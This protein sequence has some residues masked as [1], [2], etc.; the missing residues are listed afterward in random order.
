MA[1]KGLLMLDT[2]AV[3]ALSRG[4]GPALS[5]RLETQAFCIS[6]IAEAELRFGLARRPVHADVRRIVEALLATVEIRP[7]TT[8]C[9]ASYATL[10][11]QLEAAGQ[12]LSAMDFLIAAQALA[13][14]HTLVSADRALSQVPGLDVWD[15][16]QDSANQ[17]RA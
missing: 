5:A 8:A 15:W 14:G 6:V 12:P 7:W 16:T 13:E 10:R 2:N 3:S 17:P 1:V 4:R 9:A 11:T